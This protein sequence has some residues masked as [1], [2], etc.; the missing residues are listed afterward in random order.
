MA[1]S[2]SIYR[3]VFIVE[4]LV[5]P[6]PY[7]QGCPPETTPAANPV[8][9][10]QAQKTFGWTDPLG[11]GLGADSSVATNKVRRRTTPSGI[12]EVLNLANLKIGTVGIGQRVKRRHTKVLI[13]RTL[14]L[15]IRE[16]FPRLPFDHL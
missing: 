6:V 13:A 11:T 8:R 12:A 9:D 2:E 1:R 3:R 15:L 4:D 16:V 5:D 10:R 7:Y 14:G